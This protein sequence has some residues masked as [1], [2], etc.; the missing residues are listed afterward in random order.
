MRARSLLDTQPLSK[1]DL[2]SLFRSAQ[3]FRERY[4]REKTFLAKPLAHGAQRIIACIFFEPSTRTR[5][6]FEHAAYRLGHRVATLDSLTDSSLSKGESYTDTV[7]NVLAM[8]PDAIVV[9]YGESKDLD[10]LLPTLKTPIVNAGSG[11]HAH[12]TQALLDAFT[13]IRER[14]NRA[15]RLDGLK[16][17]IVGDIRHSR[18]AR[19]NFDVLGKLGCELAVCGPPVFIPDDLPSEIKVFNDLN[20]A[21]DWTDVYMGLR[22]QLERHNS[23]DS[24]ARDDYNSRFGLNLDRLKILRDDAIILHPGPINFGIEFSAE[25]QLDKRYRVLEQ[26]TNGV[27][28][29]AAVLDAIFDGRKI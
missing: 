28:I 11:T 17:L 19:S 22:V 1:T 6:S 7:L 16:V 2:E 9:R 3:E 26:V 23:R 18:V 15:G 5:L 25:A 29:R 24:F 13:L 20:E 14:G 8:E 4:Q 12:P 21:T 27:Y 10:E